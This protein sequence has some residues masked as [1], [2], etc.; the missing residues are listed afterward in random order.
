MAEQFG[1]LKFQG[2]DDGEDG[3]TGASALIFDVEAKIGETRA[4]IDFGMN[5]RRLAE[6]PKK[7]FEF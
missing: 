5:F 4:Q 1:V 6:L 3:A 2:A 7:R